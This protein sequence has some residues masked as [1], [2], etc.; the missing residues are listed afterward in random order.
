MGGPAARPAAVA[1]MS[2]ARR[3][4]RRRRLRVIERK[5]DAAPA[6]PPARRRLWRLS[7]LQIG[8]LTLSAGLLS[9][10]GYLAYCLATLSFNGGL[11]VAPSPPAMALAATDGKELA[12]R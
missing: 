5:K 4:D 7:R 2:E 10:V 9:L 3:D 8:A 6:A 1:L 11:V 12:I